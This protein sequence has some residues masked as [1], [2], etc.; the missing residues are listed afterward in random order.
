MKN[1][2]ELKQPS[3]SHS[4]TIEGGGIKRNHGLGFKES[5]SNYANNLLKYSQNIDRKLKITTDG[6]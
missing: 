2:D 1:C 5:S 4:E 6:T 3:R